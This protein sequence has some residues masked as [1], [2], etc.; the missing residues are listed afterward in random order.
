MGCPPRVSSGSIAIYHISFFW[1][2]P[3]WPN[4]LLHRQHWVLCV[5]QIWHDSPSYFP[6]QAK[7]FSM[8]PSSHYQSDVHICMCA[9]IW[10]VHQ[11]TCPEQLSTI[12]AILPDY[13][14]LFLSTTLNFWSM[15]LEKISDFDS[16]MTLMVY[17]MACQ[18]K[19]STG[20]NSFKMLFSI[21]SLVSNRY[22]KD[23]TPTL[24]QLHR[25]PM[26]Y[27]IDF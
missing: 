13:F 11:K 17:S 1:A 24:I 21:F 7:F 14:M 9:H 5:Q 15:L 26:Q 23:I 16:L 25:L 3:W 6:H 27:L 22:I 19:S 8:A 10:T 12:S 2:R 20:F 18:I 4:P